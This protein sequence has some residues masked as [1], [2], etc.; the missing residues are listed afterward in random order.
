M[1]QAGWGVLVPGFSSRERQQAQFQHAPAACG[2]V[3]YNFVLD[4]A[5]V[6]L[7]LPYLWE[8]L[9]VLSL[10]GLHLIFVAR[11][12]LMHTSLSEGQTWWGQWSSFCFPQNIMLYLW[13]EKNCL[14]WVKSDILI[15]WMPFIQGI[16]LFPNPWVLATY[17]FIHYAISTFGLCI[18]MWKSTCFMLIY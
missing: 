1:E 6:C 17:F 15:N 4:R 11:F 13:G 14:S 9:F 8:I 2:A 12:C 16:S 18:L 7:E 5:G 3:T 10:L